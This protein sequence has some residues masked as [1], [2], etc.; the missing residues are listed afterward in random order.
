MKN[1]QTND[2][3]HEIGLWANLSTAPT[4]GYRRIPKKKFVICKYNQ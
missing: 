2:I 3:K 4:I 1:T